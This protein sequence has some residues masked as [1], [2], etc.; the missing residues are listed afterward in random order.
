MGIHFM[1]HK[2]VKSIFGVIDSI[3]AISESGLITADWSG[4][5]NAAR[6]RFWDWMVGT[7][8]L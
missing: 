5:E 4:L 3:G 2:I 7:Q 8:S 6:E 1:K